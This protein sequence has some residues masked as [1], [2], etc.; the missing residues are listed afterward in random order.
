ML[1]RQHAASKSTERRRA[2]R[3]RYRQRLKVG[4]IVP[5]DFDIGAAELDLLIK[6]RWLAE[7]D[8]ADRAA[9]GRA[10]RAMLSDAAK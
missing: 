4:R 3:A 2:S 1:D 10:L 6:T 7:R 9:I 8:A 5:L